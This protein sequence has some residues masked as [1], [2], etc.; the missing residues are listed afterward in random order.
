MIERENIATVDLTAVAAA[1][2]QGI[3][4]NFVPILL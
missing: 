1:R 3:I 2:T 4:N